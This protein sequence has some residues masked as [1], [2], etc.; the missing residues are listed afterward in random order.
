MKNHRITLQDIANLA[1]VTKMTVSRYIKSPNLVAPETRKRISEI[2]EEINYIPNRAPSMLLNTKSYTIGVLI[3]SFRNHLFSDLLAGIESVTTPKQ[4][5][6]L[7]ANYNYSPEE[8]EEKIINL[9][10]YN[11]DGIILCEKNHSIKA[12]KY[13]RS[14]NIPIVEVMDSEGPCLDMEVGY[15]NKKASFDMT[16][17]MIENKKRKQVVYF[18]SQ[19]DRRDELRFQGY[20][21]GVR[22]YGLKPYIIS[23]K[24]ISS[25][26]IGEYLC[27]EAFEKYPGMDGAI[28]TNDDIAVGVLLYCKKNKISVPDEFSIA[29]FNGLEIG[30]KIIPS[31]ASVVTPRFQVGKTAAE[32]LLNKITNEN[33]NWHSIELG[34]QIYLGETI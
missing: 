19:D 27:K 4:Y 34:Y 15:D 9:L 12:V 33:F 6:T 26:E 3:P 14:S 24:T 10:S 21:L 11:I 29:G 28:C 23:P 31:I 8:E 16:K 7:I 1:D 30:R 2:M 13:L 32:I 18:G 20:T 17:T 22:E 5:Q 25:I